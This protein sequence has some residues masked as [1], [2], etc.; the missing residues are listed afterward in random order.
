MI[1]RRQFIRD[2]GLQISHRI[3]IGAKREQALAAIERAFVV[4]AIFFAVLR[5]TALAVVDLAGFQIVSRRSELAPR[6]LQDIF[7]SLSALP[8]EF[9]HLIIAGDCVEQFRRYGQALGMAS[10]CG[11]LPHFLRPIRPRP[12]VLRLADG[13]HLGHVVGV[14]ELEIDRAVFESHERIDEH[15]CAALTPKDWIVVYLRN[16][17]DD[18][19]DE[20]VL[21]DFLGIDDA[22]TERRN[23]PRLSRLLDDA[24][25]HRHPLNF[26]YPAVFAC[27]VLAVFAVEDDERA[28]PT[29]GE[30]PI[31][32]G[33]GACIEQRKAARAQQIGIEIDRRH[34]D[35]LK[36]IRRDMRWQRW[37]V[38][39]AAG[40]KVYLE[41]FDGLAERQS[42][43]RLSL[44]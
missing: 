29:I 22:G 44:R 23:L 13:A 18:F 43:A 6:V 42:L 31:A 11:L 5:I 24:G 20:T 14:Q 25:Y 8:F 3:R 17:I 34:D 10:D 15:H 38:F 19:M 12:A 9:G 37:R 35:A 30:K 7:L 40:D 27:G 32:R 1:F 2:A 4:G 41:F 21:L 39:I 28:I 33:L 36:L 16:T 26:L